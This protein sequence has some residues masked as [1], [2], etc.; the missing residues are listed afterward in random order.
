MLLKSPAIFGSP[1]SVIMDPIHG[2]IEIF[3]HEIRIIDHP[4]FLRLRHIKQNDILQYVFSGATHTRFEHSIG[5]MHVASHFFQNM[6]RNCLANGSK[7]IMDENEMRAIQYLYGCLRIAALLHDLGHMP[8]SH[9]FERSDIGKKLFN[10]KEIISGIWDGTPTEYMNAI[11]TKLEHEHLSIR[12]A[13]IVLESIKD[14]TDFP[15]EISNVIGMMENGSS[16]Y[17]SKFIE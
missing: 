5:V 17:S 8:F 16:K 3:D 11:P 14:N 13:I 12:Y 1:K 4:L 10:D 7:T 2:G 15:I 6:L 9:L